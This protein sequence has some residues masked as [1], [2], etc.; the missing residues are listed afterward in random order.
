MGAMA[1]EHGQAERTIRSE[2]ERQDAAAEKRVVSRRAKRRRQVEQLRDPAEGPARADSPERVATRIDRLS[3]YIAG[4]PLPRAVKAVDATDPDATIIAAVRR[5]APNLGQ[6]G[7]AALNAPTP[8]AAADRILEAIV[9]TVDFVGVR[10]L[11]A[12]MRAARAVGRVDIR[13][14]AGADV[15]FGTGSMVSPRLLLTNHHVLEDP[16][17]AAASQ[18]EFNFEFGLD[19]RRLRP[20]TFPFAPDAFFMTDPDLDFTLVAV[21]SEADE[22]ALARFG[23]NPL[24]A[25]EGK[26]IIGD[27]VTIVQH[28]EGHEK[29]VALREN[30]VVD[31]LDDFLHY[32]TDTQPGSSGSPV[33]NDQWE[34]VALHHASVSDPDQKELGGV[35][36]EGVRVS[37]IL[38]HAH[39]QSM[40]AGEHALLAG[41]QLA[42]TGGGGDGSERAPR[43]S[44]VLQRAGATTAAPVAPATPATTLHVRI[45]ID[46]AITLGAPDGVTAAASVAGAAGDEA[47]TIDPNYADREGFDPDFLGTGALR[48]PLP[49][50]LKALLARA[51]KAEGATGPDAHVLDY[52]HYSVVLDTQ[53]RLAFFT[54]VNIDGALA[55]RPPRESDRW[56]FDPRI[57]RD[58]QTGEQV[59]ADDDLDRGHLVRRID[60]AWGTDPVAIKFAN[61]DTFHFTNCTPQHKKFNQGDTL[62]AGLE[63]YILNNADTLNFKATVFTGPVLDPTDDAYRGVQLPRQFWKVA[64]MVRGDGRRS[65]TGYL[66]SQA[67]LIDGLEEA[68]AFDYGAYRT[69]QVPVTRIEA[70]T[71]LDFGK[72]A[73]DDPLA[74]EE[75]TGDQIRELKGPQ[76]LVL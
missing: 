28:P 52:H 65:A 72:L 23:H 17:M 57:P 24:I 46:V 68:A 74:H 67:T 30:R 15:G 54:V 58:V 19:G 38:A 66:L 33:F 13:S 45:P 42:S 22:Q 61:D 7:T 55:Q 2:A 51:A 60:P 73:D 41:L 3:R 43:A 53:R 63:D 11:E 32:S 62:W 25:A 44:R 50:L 47:V 56:S 40:T 76:D 12:G 37:R 75:A 4:D 70:L 31:V 64:V 29:Q 9:L 49:T 20:V 59:Y 10:Y 69:F 39:S 1:V 27:F 48:V 16:A 6:A 35:V 14:A 18:I 71:Q 8:E 36:N 26:A 21:G 34:V 5:A